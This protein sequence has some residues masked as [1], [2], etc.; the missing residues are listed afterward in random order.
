M[1]NFSGDGPSFLTESLRSTSSK[2]EATPTLKKK[3]PSVKKGSGSLFDDDRNDEGELFESTSVVESK[4]VKS[5]EI[6]GLFSEEDD[7]EG[8]D[9]FAAGSEAIKVPTAAAT[10]YV[11]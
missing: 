2:D 10:K 11:A 3:T 9:L 8:G 1:F 6:S 4:P 5:K 7:E